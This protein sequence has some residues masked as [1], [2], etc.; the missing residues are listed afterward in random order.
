MGAQKNSHP[1]SEGPPELMKA[2][3]QK[4]PGNN[5]SAQKG[6]MTDE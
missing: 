3:Q 5:S 4:K 2:G 1:H 6:Q